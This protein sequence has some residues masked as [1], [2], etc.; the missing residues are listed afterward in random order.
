MMPPHTAAQS[1]SL[2]AHLWV[3]GVL[4]GVSGGLLRDC[5]GLRPTGDAVTTVALDTGAQE[6]V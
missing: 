5:G 2:G 4:G 1:P 3:H 6:L